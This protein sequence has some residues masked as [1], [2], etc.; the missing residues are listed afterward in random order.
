[1]LPFGNWIHNEVIGFV[2]PAGFAGFFLFHLTAHHLIHAMQREHYKFRARPT[3][4]IC[5]SLH[6]DQDAEAAHL[7]MQAARLLWTWYHGET[8]IHQ[9]L[10]YRSHGAYYSSF[11]SS[12]NASCLHFFVR[13]G[14]R[15]F[16]KRFWLSTKQPSTWHGLLASFSWKK[17]SRFP[18]TSNLTAHA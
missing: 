10:Y 5:P 14:I 11:L 15:S 3:R 8:C 12:H 18:V 2:S 7:T 9:Q 16:C 4:A 13:R 17:I 6:V 1:M